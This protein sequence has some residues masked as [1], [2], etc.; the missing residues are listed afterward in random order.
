MAPVIL[1]STSWGG[2]TELAG[3]QVAYGFGTIISWLAFPDSPSG[4]ERP[5]AD[6]YGVV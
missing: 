3:M 5:E 6:P 4:Q 1:A 2:H